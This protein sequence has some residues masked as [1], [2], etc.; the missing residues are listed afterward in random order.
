MYLCAPSARAVHKKN[1]KLL[2]LFCILRFPTPT[3]QKL[4]IYIQSVQFLINKKKNPSF[5]KMNSAEIAEEFSFIFPGLQQRRAPVSP[6]ILII[7]RDNTTTRTNVS[8][9]QPSPTYDVIIEPPYDTP[10]QVTIISPKTASP[11]YNAPC[12]AMTH[13][14]SPQYAD[15]DDVKQHTTTKTVNIGSATAINIAKI[16][17]APSKQLTHNIAISSLI[18]KMLQDQA[19]IQSSINGIHFD[20]LHMRGRLDRLEDRE[21]KI[22]DY[23]KMI[24]TCMAIFCLSCVIVILVVIIFQKI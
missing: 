4:I 16:E 15:A 10:V 19:G 14:E 17:T 11:P 22:K 9:G 18:D 23:A 24:F 12:D 2:S 7:Q 5:Y 1:K 13:K 3:L 20:I 6:N 8:Q 21:R